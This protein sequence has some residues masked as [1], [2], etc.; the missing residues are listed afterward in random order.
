MAVVNVGSG[1]PKVRGGSLLLYGGTLVSNEGAHDASQSGVSFE[2]LGL[3]REG[4]LLAVDGVVMAVGQERDVREAYH[5]LPSGKRRSV[6][7]LSLEGRVVFPGF[8]DA[9]THPLYVGDREPDFA[10]RLDGESPVLGMA[11]TVEQTRAATDDVRERALA[12]HLRTMFRHGTTTAEVKTGYDLRTDGELALLRT[13]A[14]VA[15]RKAMPRV[16]PTLTG[17]HTHSPEYPGD[18]DAFVDALIEQT[19]PYARA[20]GAVYADAFCEPGYFTV[21]Q[22]RRYLVAARGHGLRLRLHCDEFADGG[23]AALAEE[24]GLDAADHLNCMDPRFIPGLAR[25]GTVA[26]LCPA[27]LWYMDVPRAAPARALL[28]A[29]VRVALATDFNPGTAPCPSLQMAAHLG[30]RLLG[31]SAAE[32]LVAVTSAAA[33][34]LRLTAGTLEAGARADA[35]IME[36]AHPRELGWSFGGNL[37]TAVVAAGEVYT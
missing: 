22:T 6:V 20:A 9:H 8:V 23:A 3:Y 35:V 32:A 21:E 14:D 5:A 29:G 27:T 26:V 33:R 10:A 4:A 11:Y 16:V 25:A 24:L 34:S 18:D 31:M 1:G 13:I 12:A 36:M 37:A 7:E 30:R 17:P 28:D 19:L 15:K 2:R